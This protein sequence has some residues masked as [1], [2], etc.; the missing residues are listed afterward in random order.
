[1]ANPCRSSGHRDLISQK[2]DW[3]SGSL[4]IW[5]RPL[6][7]TSR[8]FIACSQ[9]AL[10][11]RDLYPMDTRNRDIDATKS[12]R[13]SMRRRH[14]CVN[15]RKSRQHGTLKTYRLSFGCFLDIKAQIG[16]SES[17]V[18]SIT[19]LGILYERCVH[20]YHLRDDQRFNLLFG[21]MR[22]EFLCL[23]IRTFQRRQVRPGR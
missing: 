13:V 20:V 2:I 8:G 17:M 14:T 19:L 18:V 16:T 21:F 15:H 10:C 6:R 9:V 5:W 23:I 4:I 12:L 22:F 11:C 7:L 3:H 1:M